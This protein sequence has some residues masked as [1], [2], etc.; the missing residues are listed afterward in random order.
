MKALLVAALL[1]YIPSSGA[2]LKRAGSRGEGTRSREI[3]LTGT[4]DSTV[5]SDFAAGTSD[6][7]VTALTIQRDGKILVGG[8]FSSVDGFPRFGLARISTSSAT[9]DSLRVSANRD[10]VTWTRSGLPVRDS[11]AASTGIVP[12]T[13]QTQRRRAAVRR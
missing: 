3:T 11:R 13:V 2:L 12:V 8:T 4:L 7:A 9:A 10:V 6:P 5:K 1:A